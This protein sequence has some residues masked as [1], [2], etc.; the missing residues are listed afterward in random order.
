MRTSLNLSVGFSDVPSGHLA[1]V[2]TCL[3]MRAPPIPRPA[4]PMADNIAL[5]ILEQPSVERYRSLYRA[6]GEEWLWY[7]RLIMPD[8]QLRQILDDHQVIVAALRLANRDIGIL[9]LDFRQSRTC[10]LA[11]F[12]L[13]SNSIGEGIGRNLMNEAINLAWSQPID[14]FWV[15]TCTLDHPG[16]LAFYR[17][18]GFKPYKMQIEVMPDPRVT[19]VIPKNCAAHI[20]I[21]GLE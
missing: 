11:L 8:P 12:G 17:R 15:H 13:A 20:P 18:S 16:A 2:V 7:S 21:I 10:E 4:P 1:T 19:G 6:I 3:E 14:R 9:E 5:Q